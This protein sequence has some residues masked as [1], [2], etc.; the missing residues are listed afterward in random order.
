LASVRRAS[1]CALGRRQIAAAQWIAPVGAE[2]IYPR[3]IVL[4]SVMTFLRI[5]IPL[6][7]FV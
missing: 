7:L 3:V 6:Q 1:A 4:K 5:V 2:R